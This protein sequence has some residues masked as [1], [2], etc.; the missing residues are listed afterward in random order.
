MKKVFKACRGHLEFQNG[1]LLYKIRVH[2]K[3]KYK[4]RYLVFNIV[5][6]SSLRITI[7]SQGSHMTLTRGFILYI[8]I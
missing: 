7:M 3:V 1:H 2:I 6:L 4:S 5:V 8:V